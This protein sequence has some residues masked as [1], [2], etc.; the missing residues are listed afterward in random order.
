MSNHFDTAISWV[1]CLFAALTAVTAR[2][3]RDLYK[4]SEQIPTDP[5][6]LRHWQRRRRWMIWSELAALP[7]FATI[8]VASVI[9]LEVPVVLA[10]LIAIGLG[11][12][13][14]GFLLNGL[15]AIIRKKLGIEP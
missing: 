4:V 5:L 8:S 12:L 11:G 9:Y 10:V 3:M 7:C 6:E 14:F 1:A 15:Q 2:L 13:G